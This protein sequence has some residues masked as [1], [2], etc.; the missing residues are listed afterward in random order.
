MIDH[1]MLRRLS[2][3]LVAGGHGEHRLGLRR[4]DWR[5]VGLHRGHPT[6]PCRVAQLVVASVAQ[7]TGGDLPAPLRF[8]HAPNAETAAAGSPVDVLAE[9]VGLERL[10]HGLLAVLA[11]HAQGADLL[12]QRGPP[13]LLR[14]HQGVLMGRG[15]GRAVRAGLLLVPRDRRGRRGSAEVDK[16]HGLLDLLVQLHV[17]GKAH[18]CGQLQHANVLVL[19]EQDLAEQRADGQLDGKDDVDGELDLAVGVLPRQVWEQR[20]VFGVPI[21]SSGSSHVGFVVIRAVHRLQ[22]HEE[23]LQQD[24]NADNELKHE[25]CGRAARVVHEQI[26]AVRH[27]RFSDLIALVCIDGLGELGSGQ[28]AW[29][30][31]AEGP[32]AV[33]GALVAAVGVGSVLRRDVRILEALLH[34]EAGS[35]GVQNACK[36]R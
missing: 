14:Q 10:E 9:V 6:G 18:L 4:R 7:G 19:E 33:L 23:Q 11:L 36:G 17:V 8:L 32:V 28:G 13:A 21:D 30:R 35:L 15:A 22:R 26:D 2:R 31:E 12:L 1:R 20:Q 34:R 16:L 29:A 27:G 3:R 5:V 24:E 25:G